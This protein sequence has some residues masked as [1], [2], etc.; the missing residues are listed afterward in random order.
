MLCC[1]F[2]WVC[3]PL[4]AHNVK[5]N[6]LKIVS[7]Q[8]VPKLQPDHR[9]KTAVIVLKTDTISCQQKRSVSENYPMTCPSTH[10]FVFPDWFL[11]QKKQSSL[12]LF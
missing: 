10:L 1:A 8:T 9:Q 5:R 7:I 11:E 12:L 4:S 2:I 3:Q 6:V